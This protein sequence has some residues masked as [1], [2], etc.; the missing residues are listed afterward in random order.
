MG[1]SSSTYT[2]SDSDGIINGPFGA[3]EHLERVLRLYERAV[4]EAVEQFADSEK[5]RVRRLASSVENNWYKLRESLNVRYDY[6]TGEFVYEVEGDELVNQIA[7]E[8]E[9][10]TPG[11]PPNALLRSAALDGAQVSDLEVAN[12]IR[13]YIDKRQS[14]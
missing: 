4:T 13:K 11:N 14:W 10:G 6:E 5:R 3:V 9:Y 2:L 12:G 8:L 7:A 1:G